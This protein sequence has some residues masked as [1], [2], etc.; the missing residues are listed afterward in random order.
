MLPIPS[1]HMPHKRLALITHTLIGL[2][3]ACVMYSGVPT[4]L[5]EERS[6]A[7]G[8]IEVVE[9]RM[10]ISE[11]SPPLHRKQVRSVAMSVYSRCC[12]QAMVRH[13]SPL[14]AVGLVVSLLTLLLTLTA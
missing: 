6:E 5:N 12:S 9:P 11:D 7:R 10:A 4:V 14:S 2:Y 3:I 13:K 1:P 8:G